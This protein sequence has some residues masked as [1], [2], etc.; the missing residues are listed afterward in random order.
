MF[1]VRPCAEEN[2]EEST[3]REF[4]RVLFFRDRFRNLAEIDRDANG[5]RHADMTNRTSSLA[6]FREN[7]GDPSKRSSRR[8]RHTV[9]N[10]ADLTER[11]DERKNDRLFLTRMARSAV[12]ARERDG[13][14]PKCS[15]GVNELGHVRSRLRPPPR[16]YTHYIG[17]LSFP[18]DRD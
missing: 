14:C 3:S 2:L 4:D 17:V 1:C 15:G 5:A 13:E 12:C 6:R 16:L 9:A 18:W 7:L 10:R 8:K 11:T